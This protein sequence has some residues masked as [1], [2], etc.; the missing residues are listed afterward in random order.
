M[1]IGRTLDLCNNHSDNSTDLTAQ[2]NM[3]K[4]TIHKR[5]GHILPVLLILW[6]PKTCPFPTGSQTFRTFQEKEIMA[7]PH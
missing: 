1:L 7:K 6:D 4:H 5:G 2:H 3:M